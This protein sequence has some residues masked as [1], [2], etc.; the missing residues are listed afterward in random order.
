MPSGALLRARDVMTP[1][2]VTVR[3]EDSAWTALEL[4]HSRGVG[5]LVVVEGLKPVGIVTERDI[6]RKVLTMRGREDLLSTFVRD[7]MSG[8]LITC[9]PETPLTTVL[10]IMVDKNI[11]RVPVVS[12]GMLD[13]IVTEWSCIKALLQVLRE[14]K[15]ETQTS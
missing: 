13:G 10:E 11:R 14:E 3:P 15:A 4:M 1:L 12:G 6:L 5:A 2:V 7:V 9:T 8:R